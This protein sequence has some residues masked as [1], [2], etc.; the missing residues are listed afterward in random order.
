M[1]EPKTDLIGRRKFLKKVGLGLAG[2][3]VAAAG[4]GTQTTSAEAGGGL[5]Q[6]IQMDYMSWWG[7]R[8]EEQDDFLR[9]SL[10]K[11]VVID[12]NIPDVR[13]HDVFTD[14]KN[15]KRLVDLNA[16]SWQDTEK[17]RL[18]LVPG[19][20]IDSTHGHEGAKPVVMTEEQWQDIQNKWPKEEL[21]PPVN[22]IQLDSVIPDKTKLM[23]DVAEVYNP[24]QAKVEPM[25]V[26]KGFVASRT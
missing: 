22:G 3:A 14:G 25:L 7:T 23:F 21:N 6:L 2:T 18:P 24:Q 12:V 11:S 20:G 16:G 13:V 15:K 17:Y 8:R 1:S 9:N 10:G 26:F 19:E 4:L 5:P